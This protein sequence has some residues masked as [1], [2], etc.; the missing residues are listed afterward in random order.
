VIAS[1]LKPVDDVRNYE[2]IGKSLASDNEVVIL[3]TET[4]AENKPAIKH[5]SWHPFRRLRLS[6][7]KVQWAFWKKLKQ[8]KPDIIIITT[9]ELLKTVMFYRLF[10]K[11]R[12]VYDVQEDYFRNL[13]YQSFYPPV[14]RHTAAIAIRS[15]EWLS[16]PLISKFLLA[17]KVYANDIGFVKKKAVILENKTC[18]IPDNKNR[19]PF[20]VVFTGTISQYTQ[21]KESIELYL[22]IKHSLPESE[23]VVIGYTPNLAYHDML[24]SR[25]A[26]KVNLKISRKPVPHQEIVD[27]ISKARLGIIGYE[28]NPVN[29]KKVPTKLFEYT[30][31]RLP[32]LVQSG[33][34]WAHVGKMLG[35]AIPIEFNQPDPEMIEK[36]LYEPISYQNSGYR[37]SEVEPA[38]QETIRQL[39]NKI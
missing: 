30:E 14:I 8:E 9:F 4:Q 15:L 7:L 5:Y 27:E 25:F 16:T 22:R 11:T 24:I 17:E 32:Y 21:A 29:E 12:V 26:D 34:H 36:A 19:K 37:W 38:L 35:G 28:P 18:P 3:G 1:V 10:H 39:K 23:M 33:T 13:W 20:K 31:A 6:R 2:K